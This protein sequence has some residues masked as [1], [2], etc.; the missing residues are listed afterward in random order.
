MLIEECAAFNTRSTSS[1]RP[2]DCFAGLALI[3]PDILLY[4][5]RHQLRFVINSSGSHS[6]QLRQHIGDAVGL[7]GRREM[8]GLRDLDEP[9]AGHV[10]S[11]V[12]Q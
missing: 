9:S 8:G 3:L 5:A 7:F 11:D 4:A 1:R 2:R 10:A 12:P 6:P